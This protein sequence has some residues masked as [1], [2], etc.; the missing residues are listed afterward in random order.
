VRK[1]A[2]SAI[3]N[4]VQNS[5]RCMCRR[6][7][8]K[9]AGGEVIYRLAGATGALIAGRCRIQSYPDHV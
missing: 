6:L 2:K 9:F 3:V 4:Y 8:V 1:F 7:S 5:E